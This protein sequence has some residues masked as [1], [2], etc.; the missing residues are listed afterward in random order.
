MF[1]WASFTSRVSCMRER[2][3][4][5]L[6]FCHRSLCDCRFSLLSQEQFLLDTPMCTWYETASVLGVYL[7]VGVQ[8]L[9]LAHPHVSAD[10]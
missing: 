7:I 1:A 3:L 2:G 5:L 4:T 10:F 9:K 8:I 6:E